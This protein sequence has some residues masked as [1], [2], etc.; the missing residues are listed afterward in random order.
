M[1]AYFAGSGNN[2]P[3]RALGRNRRPRALPL[4]FLPCAILTRL[5]CRAYMGDGSDGR[6][7]RWQSL[8][9][10]RPSRREIS[11]V[12]AERWPFVRFVL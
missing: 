6:N 7:G 3:G 10:K 4:Y 2:F 11:H 1:F 8:T 12:L 5:H 9:Q